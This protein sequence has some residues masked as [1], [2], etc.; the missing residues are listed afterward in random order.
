MKFINSILIVVVASLFFGSSCEKEKSVPDPPLVEDSL[1]TVLENNKVIYELNIRNFSA[2]GT[3]AAVEDKLDYLEDLGVDIIWLMPIHPSGVKNKNGSLGSPYAVKDYKA[4]SPDYGTLA[5][6]R[7]LVTAAHEKGMEIWLD[8]VANHTAWDHDWVTTHIDYYATNGSGQRPY[9]PNGWLD[10]IQLDFNNANM[11]AAMIDAMKYW[12]EQ[13]DIDGFRCDYATGVP[14]TFWQEAKT[15]INSIK[16]EFTWLAE[17]DLPSYMAVFDYDF[18][19]GFN[20][21]LNN[22]GKSK[23]VA[24]LR[25]ACEKLYSHTS[26][27]NAARMVYLT[28]H[29][30]NAY[31]G[32]EFARYGS[33][34]APLTVLEFTIYDMPLI[35]NGQEI[36]YNQS[37]GLFDYAKISWTP[38]PNQSINT[39]I[40]KLTRLK[41]T[42]LALESGANRGTLLFYTMSAGDVLCYS[43]EKGGSQVIV[44]LNFSAMAKDVTFNGT[45]PSGTF[46]DYFKNETVTVNSAS[47]FSLPA[48]GYVVLIKQQ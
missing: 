7:S 31:D 16:P 15:V 19:W 2:A 34:V 29:D 26:Y 18:A 4:V 14:L 9:S 36:G 30:L 3:I 44:M 22:F 12:V 38:V 25:T 10:V 17:G 11:R 27:S 24:A 5:D 32:T 20:T 42:T 37:M 46:K 28:N 1:G 13:A 8:W 43:R 6:L 35:Y 45:T 23:D 41:R 48:N 21:A 33:F 39:L 40:K 47:S